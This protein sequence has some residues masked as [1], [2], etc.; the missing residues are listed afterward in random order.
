M[1]GAAIPRPRLPGERAGAFATLRAAA[2]RLVSRVMEHGGCLVCRTHWRGEGW[3]PALA[4]AAKGSIILAANHASLLDTP[5]IR[6][7][8]PAALERRLFTVGGYDFFEPR[9]SGWARLRA[10]VVLRFIVDSYRVW[11]IDRRVEGAAAVAE[12]TGLLTRERVMLLY[13]E[14][15]RSRTGRMGRVQ[16]GV[17]IIAAR[18]GAPVIPVHISGSHR[19]LPPGVRWPQP[20]AVVVRAGAPLR[21]APQERPEA[22]ALRVAAAIQALGDS[23]GPAAPR[24]EREARSARVEAGAEAP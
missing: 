20:G 16:P 21:P 18:S 23:A 15:T 10:R 4:E 2:L 6:H 12:L 13:P 5:M 9:G 14:G 8:L 7:V 1:T 17:A 11:M 22:F 24:R 3:E 19:V